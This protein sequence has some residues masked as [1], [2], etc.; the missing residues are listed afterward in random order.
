VI[1]V[2]IQDNE[3]HDLLLGEMSSC[4][5][6]SDFTVLCSWSKWRPKPLTWHPKL[7]LEL[8]ALLKDLDAMVVGVG[9]DDVL[10]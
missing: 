1:S 9:H 5:E 3:M 8:P 10:V 4:P 2:I 6:L 7:V